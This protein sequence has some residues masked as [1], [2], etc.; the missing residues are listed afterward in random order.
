MTDMAVRHEDGEW[1][2]MERRVP[3]GMAQAHATQLIGQPGLKASI[4]YR[5]AHGW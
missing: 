3:P 1:V 5:V 4:T 2:A